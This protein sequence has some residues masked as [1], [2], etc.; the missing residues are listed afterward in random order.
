MESVAKERPNCLDLGFDSVRVS[1]SLVAP[2]VLTGPASQF[3]QGAIDWYG[4][5]YPKSSMGSLFSAEGINCHNAIIY[6]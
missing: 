3:N 4:C 2:R 1:K 5:L 6:F